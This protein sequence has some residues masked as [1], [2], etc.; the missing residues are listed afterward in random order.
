MNFPWNYTMNDNIHVE[1]CMQLF[2]GQALETHG[3]LHE[4]SMENPRKFH[5]LV[6]KLL[7]DWIGV[8]N[9]WLIGYIDTVDR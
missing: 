5:G 1:P 7:L 4:Y 2:H 9:A 3:R 6:M 8:F